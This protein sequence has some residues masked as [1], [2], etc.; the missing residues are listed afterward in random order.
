[1]TTNVQQMG[2]GQLQIELREVLMALG[3]DPSN[4][5]LATR[6]DQLEEEIG[7]RMAW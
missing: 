1:M 7:R 3:K 4:K 2:S 6:A 5:K